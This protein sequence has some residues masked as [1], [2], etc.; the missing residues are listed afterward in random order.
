[1]QLLHSEE[2][3]EL[4]VKI[5]KARDLISSDSNGF[6]DPYCK[7]CM[8]PGRESENKRRTKTVFKNLNPV[9]NETFIF[10]DL[11]R[12]EAENKILEFTFYDWDRF[13]R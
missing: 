3:K 5:I 10:P 11:Y 13:S 7:L 1:M 8:L 12:E 2:S 4:S 6:S 9:W